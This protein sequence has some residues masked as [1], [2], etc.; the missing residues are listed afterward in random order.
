MEALV[1][2]LLGSFV[3]AFAI[4][5]YLIPILCVIA[6]RL[7]FIDAPDGTI[8]CQKNPTPYF[9]GVAVYLGFITALVFV[10]P[11]QSNLFFFLVGAT[12]LM[13][14]GL[15]DDFICLTPRQKFWGQCIAC[16]GFL[17]AGLY[18]KA[19]FF[20]SWWAIPLSL[21]WMLSIIN[22][23]NL[24]DVMDGL[25]ATIAISAA[26]GFCVFAFILK[27]YAVMVV[28][29]ALI[30]ALTAFLWYNRPTARI[31]LGDAGSLFVGGV[32]AA[33]PFWLSWG[34]Y[35]PYGFLVPIIV[36]AIPSLEV[37]SLIVIRRIKG[38]PFYKGSLDHF[39]SYM[40]RH[41]LGKYHIL[42]LILMLSIIL[43][44]GA[45]LIFT[46]YLSLPGIAISS[47][48]FLLLWLYLVFFYPPWHS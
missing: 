34:M 47:I 27:A 39:S 41:G 28:L 9:G 33:T 10:F 26:F 30:G 17:R 37:V 15:I 3:V 14:V 21:F 24:V 22:A 12:F 20:M 45:F 2:N 11:F 18:L 29:I 48:F 8:K 16:I 44:V 23:F 13:L 7:N 42:S 31:Y 40:Q 38:I 46:G 43:N 4:T 5:F 1:L 25:T 32:L 19:Q 6:R 35:S 36:L